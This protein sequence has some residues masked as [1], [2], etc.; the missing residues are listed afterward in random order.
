ML[1]G[2]AAEFYY[3]KLAD[4]NLDFKQIID[5]MKLHFE[6]EENRQFYLSEW[7]EI[8]FQK[9]INENPSKTRSDYLQILFNQLYKFQ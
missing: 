7:R 9:V 5:E 3:E 2:Q 4:K 6:T 1:K 8:T